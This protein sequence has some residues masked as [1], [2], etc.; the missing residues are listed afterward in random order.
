MLSEYLKRGCVPT[1]EILRYAVLTYWLSFVALSLSS[2]Y[3]AAPRDGHLHFRRRLR[4]VKHPFR[5]LF[6]RA[7]AEEST[8]PAGADTDSSINLQ[9]SLCVCVRSGYSRMFDVF[10]SS[11]IL[12]TRRPELRLHECF[13]KWGV[14]GG[15]LF[16]SRQGACRNLVSHSKAP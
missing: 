2:L 7:L 8:T 11:V 12:R 4:Q 6:G 13:E 10:L 1:L 3:P 16:P 5:D 15:Y 9:V 14:A